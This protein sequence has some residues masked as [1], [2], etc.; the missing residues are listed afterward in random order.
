MQLKKYNIAVIDGEQVR[1]TVLNGQ[2]CLHF[3]DVGRLINNQTT[4]MHHITR[5]HLDR[6]GGYYLV[7]E[8]QNSQRKAY[9]V[10][11]PVMFKIINNMTNYITVRAQFLK[12]F[13]E[14]TFKIKCELK[15]S[16]VKH[17]RVCGKPIPIP[18]R[19]YPRRSMYCS[20]KCQKLYHRNQ[21]HERWLAKQAERNMTA[22]CPNCGR[23][24]EKH[25]PQQIFCCGVCGNLFRTSKRKE[26]L[27]RPKSNFY[28]PREVYPDVKEPVWSSAFNW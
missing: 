26:R 19:G 28:N 23:T 1:Y 4:M 27:S 10:S 20:D 25:T 9:Y 2:P 11:V 22:V 16:E 7:Y 3:R 6:D 15:E 12:D 8:Y 14:K 21:E 13:C 18:E 5:L 17:C 24:F